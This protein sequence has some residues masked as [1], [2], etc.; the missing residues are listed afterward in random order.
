MNILKTEDQYCNAKVYDPE[1]ALYKL[2]QHTLTNEQYYNH[3]NTKAGVGITNGIK[4][5]RYPSVR[6]CTINVENKN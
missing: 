2:Q 5:K 4:R 6:N 1:C 3:F